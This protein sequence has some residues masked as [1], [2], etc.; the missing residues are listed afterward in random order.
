MSHGK[1]PSAEIAEAVARLRTDAATGRLPF[2]RWARTRGLDA[3]R[4]GGRT[5]VAADFRFV[6]ATGRDLKRLADEGRFRLDLLYRIDTLV[7]EMPP[8]RERREDIP[9]LADHFL[10]LFSKNAGKEIKG[11]TPAALQRMMLYPWPGNIRELQNLI[12]RSVILTTGSTLHVAIPEL[13]EQAGLPALPDRSSTAQAAERDRIIKALEEA[14]GQVGGPNGAA[15][16]LGLKRTTL[17]SRM[18]KYNIARQYC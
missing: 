18:R 3:W 11:F 13:T 17:Q 16:R 15:A 9:L 2:Q 10:K 8:L 7:L 4:L 12:E 5:S 6:S 1:P 14:K